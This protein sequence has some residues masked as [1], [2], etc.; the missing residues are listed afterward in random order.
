[1]GAS[2][3]GTTTFSRMTLIIAAINRLMLNRMT[4]NRMTLNRIKQNIIEHSRMMFRRM[5][6]IM[7]ANIY[8]MILK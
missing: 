6:L 7:M 3:L 5:T 4:L 2:V 8:R 1:M